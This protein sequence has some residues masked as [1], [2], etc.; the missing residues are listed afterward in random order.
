MGN[1]QGLGKTEDN[2]ACFPSRA[3]YLNTI[4]LIISLIAKAHPVNRE[5]LFAFLLWLSCTGAKAQISF[6]TRVLK[7]S[8]FIPWE[9]TYGPDDHLWFTQK[10][11]YICRMD[12][13]GIR[14][15]TIYH[16]PAT[17]TVK[18]SGMLGMALH[19]DFA[20]NPYVYVVWEYFNPNND[21]KEHIV[22]Y[23]Y[24][25]ATNRLG[26]PLVI[27]DSTKGG[28]FHNGSRLIIVG[29][30]LFVSVGDATD[31]TNPQNL[32]SLNGKILRLNLDGSIPA[33]NPIP[34]SAIWTWGHRNPQGLVYANG[35]LYSSEHGNATD[36]EINII[37]KGHNYGWPIVEGYCDQPGELTFCADSNVTVPIY[38][39]TPTIAPCGI[40]Y[41]NH[42]MFPALRRSLLLTTL[43]DQHLYQLQLNDTYDSIVSAS[44]I[45]G[46][47]YGRL[48]DIC[49]SPEGKIFASTSNSNPNDTGKKV[50]KIIVM[51]D[52]AFAS[53]LK[54]TI[55]PNPTTDIVSFAIPGHYSSLLYNLS[56]AAD[57]RKIETG[58]LDA[59]LPRL[60]LKL[61]PDGMYIIEIKTNEGFRYQGKIIVKH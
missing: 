61:L 30:K 60:N 41:Y 55:Y 34:G 39:W 17:V 52:P 37:V 16:E 20:S 12:T 10:N 6:T 19:P 31:I 2:V 58:T 50:D 48:R 7:D 4:I 24:D 23:T 11:G 5:L 26:S 51:Y 36:D 14:T 9:L 22:R 15:D 59:T 28:W 54:F 35:I 57:S 21:I 44:V 45:T 27:F 18:E 53:P 43:K 40:D 29:D 33:D 38:A 3:W 25:A 42:I 49:T 13:A 47:D 32:N 46:F 56:I 8:L 1:I